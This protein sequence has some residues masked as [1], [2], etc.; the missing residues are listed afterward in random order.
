LIG[1]CAYICAEEAGK[2][3][4]E[5]KN[6]KEESED[7][8]EESSSTET[9]ESDEESESDSEDEGKSLQ[10]TAREKARQRLQVNFHKTFKLYHVVIGSVKLFHVGS[11]RISTVMVVHLSDL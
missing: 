10:E 1:C 5:V 8:E 4:T 11:Y 6:E 3:E 7:E 9:D 2:K